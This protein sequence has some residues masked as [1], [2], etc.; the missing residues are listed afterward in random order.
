MGR[1]NLTSMSF[2]LIRPS[3]YLKEKS[4][5]QFLQLTLKMCHIANVQ[6]VKIVLRNNNNLSLLAP[7]A[8]SDKIHSGNFI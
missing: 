7:E 5:F 6:T 4:L 3:L 1:Y 8:T 2:I